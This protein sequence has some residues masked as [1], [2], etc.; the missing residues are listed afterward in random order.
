MRNARR[1]RGGEGHELGA[2]SLCLVGRDGRPNFVSDVPWRL[3]LLHE[4]E[5]FLHLAL[6]LALSYLGLLT[7]LRG[8]RSRSATCQSDSDICSAHR[9]RSFD[10]SDDSLE[11][12]ARSLVGA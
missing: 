6:S 3:F 11:S 5:L 2:E 8:L 7:S 10:L 4:G 9:A 1:R 12:L